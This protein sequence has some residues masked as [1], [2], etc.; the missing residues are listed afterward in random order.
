MTTSPPR[1]PIKIE[2]L[3]MTDTSDP[4]HHQPLH[5]GRSDGC[6]MIMKGK[7]TPCGHV[8]AIGLKGDKLSNP[9]EKFHVT[10]PVANQ[11]QARLQCLTTDPPISSHY[12]FWKIRW[13]L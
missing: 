4:P 13:L 7:K 12:P 2:Q 5:A 3:S 9:T 6:C 8:I 11:E 10:K 1:Q